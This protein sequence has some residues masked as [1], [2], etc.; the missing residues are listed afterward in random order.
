MANR[1]E[2]NKCT[3]LTQALHD[4]LPFNISITESTYTQQCS[5]FAHERSEYESSLTTFLE[6]QFI[7]L[8]L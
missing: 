2:A 8:C 5:V 3:N 6:Y 4:D 1:V 7:C